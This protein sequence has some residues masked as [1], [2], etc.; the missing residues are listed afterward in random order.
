MTDLTSACPACRLGVGVR[1][2]G[3]GMRACGLGVGVRARVRLGVGGR[4]GAAYLGPGFV[5]G[6]NPRRWE[7]R[8]P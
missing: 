6:T 1:A 7:G 8:A 2:G 3:R 4:T 5:Q